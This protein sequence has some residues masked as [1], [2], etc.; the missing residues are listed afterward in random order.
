MTYDIHIMLV[1]CAMSPY[2]WHNWCCLRGDCGRAPAFFSK[3]I[4]CSAHRHE[5]IQNGYHGRKTAKSELT[6]LGR[7]I[8]SKYTTGNG[9]LLFT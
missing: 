6:A 1:S 8:S 9:V 7:S 2:V 3:C 4:P 5:L